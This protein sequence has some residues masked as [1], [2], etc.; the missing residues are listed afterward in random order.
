MS[1][2]LASTNTLLV[3]VFQNIKV[4]IR[5][6]AG[7]NTHGENGEAAADL[8]EQFRLFKVLLDQP[9][10]VTPAIESDLAKLQNLLAKSFNQAVQNDGA[11]T[12]GVGL[13][14]MANQIAELEMDIR[15][16]GTPKADPFSY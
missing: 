11:K 10:P 15:G 12:N 4:A 8:T 2:L 13:A 14:R 6:A 3:E 7:N 16:S 9:Q 5:Q 1:E